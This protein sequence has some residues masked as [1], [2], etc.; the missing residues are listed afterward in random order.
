[1]FDFRQITLYRRN[2][3]SV[4]TPPNT[5]LSVPLFELGLLDAPVVS[6]WRAEND[7]PAWAGDGISAFAVMIASRQVTSLPWS[8]GV[9]VRVVIAR[10]HVRCTFQQVWS[11]LLFVPG[12][13]QH[14][15]MVFAEK[16]RCA[17][18]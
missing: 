2:V 4:L 14:I 6:R 13:H 9:L 17:F 7:A 5:P 16:L 3:A 11:P 8:F 18:W 10:I 12:V 15:V 1:M